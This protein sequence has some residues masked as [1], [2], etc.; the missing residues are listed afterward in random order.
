[1]ENNLLT[2]FFRVGLVPYLQIAIIGMKRNTLFKH[3]KSMVTC[4]EMM[5]DAKEYQ[6]LLKPSKKLEK[7]LDNIQIEKMCDFCHN[8]GHLKKHCH[9]NPKNPNNRL[10][11]KKEVSVNKISL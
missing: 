1:M 8:P 5:V 7:T 6:K 4:E 2:T 3:K 10:K 11:D 9:W